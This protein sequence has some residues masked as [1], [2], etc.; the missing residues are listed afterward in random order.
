MTHRKCNFYDCTFENCK[1]SE[2]EWSRVDFYST[3]F[4]NCN[5]Q[6]L[7]L[8]NSSLI[9]CELLETNWDKVYLES[10]GFSNMKIHKTTFT[11]LKFSQNS[12]SS[13]GNL[14][15]SIQVH[16]SQTFHKAIKQLF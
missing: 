2:C 6:N 7:H 5:F 8:K 11:N 14:E 3:R 4:I 12:I 15:E 13:I 9:T 1:L 10:I 16:D